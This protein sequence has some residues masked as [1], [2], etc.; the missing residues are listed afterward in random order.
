ME[1]WKSINE[2]Y[3]VSNLGRIR[4]TKNNR[5]KYLKPEVLK[6]GYLRVSIWE[7]GVRKRILVHRLVAQMFIPNKDKTKTQ[8]DH[9][10]NNTSDNRVENLRWVTPKENIQ[11]SIEQGRFV[12]EIKIKALKNIRI[13]DD[14]LKQLKKQGFKKGNIP[15]NKGKK[16]L[17]FHT[18]E[19]KKQTSLRMKKRME[20]KQTS[21]IC[22]ETGEIFKS[23]TEA[24]KNKKI[25]QGNINSCLR[26][27][28][29]IAGG[30]HWQ[31]YKS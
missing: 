1:N 24:S 12:T 14:R 2:E 15:W 28:R 8:I 23:Q 20:E 4:R 9:I 29:N 11:H 10:N 31:Y 18:E 26:G 30:Y 3:E 27:K 25:S 21:I 22:I 5:T 6:K 7:N 17:Q 19:R 13:T 16:G